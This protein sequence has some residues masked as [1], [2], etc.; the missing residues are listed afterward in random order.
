VGELT[1]ARGTFFY[2]PGA[3]TRAGN[4]AEMC[5]INP[6]HQMSDKAIST[7]SLS[8]ESRTFPPAPAVVRHALINAAQYTAMY[9]RSL[10][11]PDQ[12]WLEQAH[13]LEWFKP[14]KHALKFNWDTNARKVE[15]TWFEDG[16]LNLTVN[17]LDRH[18]KT[19]G[20]QTAIIWQGEPEDEVKRITYAELHH[21]V[22]KFA[23]V[24][25]SLG[26]KKGDRVAIYMPM[27]PEAAVAMLGCAR[28]GAIHSV[29]FGGFSSDSLA[30]RINDSEC[31]LLITANVSLRAGKSLA[32][33]KLADDALQHTPS[34]QKV[35]VV[36]R[37][38]EPCNLTAGRDVW[39]HELMAT[40]KVECPPEKLNAEDY[41]FV[42]YTSGSTGKPKGVVHSTAGYLLWTAL[43]HKYVFDIHDGDVFY[44]TADIG[45]VTGHSYV[46]Y[47]PL[48]NGG[49][50]VM[51]EGVPTYP[52]AGRFW[53]IV[54]KFKVSSFYTAPTAIRALIRLGDEW[55][56]KYDLSSLRVLGTVGEPINPE[57]WMWYH[58]HI[59]RERCPIVDTW[60]QTETGGHLI[61][62]LPGAHTLKPG[63]ASK[64]FFGVEP[65]VLRDDGIECK[66][67][68]GGKLCIK[69][70]WPGIM[71][72][73]WGDHHRFINTYFS[74]FKDMY[75]TGDGCRVDADGDYWLLGRVDDVVNVSGHRIGTAEVESALVSHAK[76]AE[77]AVAP[78]PHDIKG[79]ALYAFVT[80][81]DGIAESED[82]KKE[83]AAHVRKEIGAIAVPDK[84]QFA[85]GLP[86]TRSG[87]I[88]R[89]ILRKIAENQTDQIGDIT[90]LA[91]PGVVDALV[92][93]K[94]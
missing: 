61:T 91:D 89:R 53:K 26:V 1:F 84:I 79:Q 73:T 14:P 6:I 31:K 36:K 80:L 49:T 2:F 21:E 24:L 28:I 15:H 20:Q 4:F 70:P 25:K 82:L 94:Q 59:G 78:M 7:E 42:L 9:Q 10:R 93:G 5:K 27:I 54:E 65:V 71:R 46:V 55:P 44:C 66:P 83:L 3:L 32:L 40:A 38:D 34:I 64:P 72:T 77:A 76:V 8:H 48:C 87:K 37:N 11:E 30:G 60:W 23:N 56:A 19:R 63:S 68:E 85:P 12:F 33:K 67:N 86:K 74:T 39:Y 88:M 57:A 52:D 62:A 17:C 35:I 16:Q 92:K 50:T 90:T 18:L 29:V 43:T 47:G 58:R 81:K 13:T 75:F 45:W 41:L 22:C 51:F 69:K